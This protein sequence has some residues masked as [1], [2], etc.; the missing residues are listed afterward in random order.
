[1]KYLLILL[2]TACATSRCLPQVDDQ[3][4]MRL[5]DSIDKYPALYTV[6]LYRPDTSIHGKYNP[7]AHRFE[8]YERQGIVEGKQRILFYNRVYDRK[9]AYVVND[10]SVKEIDYIDPKKVRSITVITDRPGL[11]ISHWGAEYLIIVHTK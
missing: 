11:W 9:Y 2:L 3:H 4:I 10:Q 8:G 1:M 7:I 6:S 5:I